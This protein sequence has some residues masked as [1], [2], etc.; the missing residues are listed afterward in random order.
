MIWKMHLILWEGHVRRRRLV[1][2]IVTFVNI[3]LF[4]QFFD[5]LLEFFLEYG[6]QYVHLILILDK[7]VIVWISAAFCVI[8]II[9]NIAN[10]EVLHFSLV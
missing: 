1:S 9:F 8:G 2:I 7:G 5:R 6:R 10:V 3:F 4:Y